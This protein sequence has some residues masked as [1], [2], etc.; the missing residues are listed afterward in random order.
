MDRMNDFD[1]DINEFMEE[2]V[3]QVKVIQAIFDKTGF[4]PRVRFGIKQFL[5]TPQGETDPWGYVSSSQMLTMLNTVTAWVKTNPS[6]LDISAD[7]LVVTTKR[8][9]AASGAIGY[10][11][12]GGVCD[13]ERYTNV[14]AVSK[15]DILYA[16][17]LIAHEF[18]HTFGFRHDGDSSGGTSSCDAI[19]DIM[20]PV[21]NGDETVFSQ[22]SIDQYNSGTYRMSGTL[23]AVDHSCLTQPTE[24]HCGNG[25][26]EEGED[27]DCYN[28]DCTGIDASCNGSTCKFL[29][30]KTCSQLHDTCCNSGQNGPAASGTVCRASSGPCDKVE[31]CDGTS[32]TCPT[33]LFE[34]LGMKCVV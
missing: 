5:Y 33:D 15:G 32:V 8:N 2:S 13:K 34:P 29:P 26:R 21:I 1:Y 7:S 25:I 28:N 10:A 16:G 31:T 20:G 11:W 12:V 6:S 23:Y 27:C 22:C 30:G 4:N 14:N 9:M 18:G 17:T 19:P 3:L 24:Y